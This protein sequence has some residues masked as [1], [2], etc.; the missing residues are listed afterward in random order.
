M[1]FSGCILVPVSFSGRVRWNAGTAGTLKIS[2]HA[3]GR[4]NP[5]RL[6]GVRSQKSKV[7]YNRVSGAVYLLLLGNLQRPTLA[8]GNLAGDIEGVQTF[9]SSRLVVVF[10]GEEFIK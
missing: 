1:I 2:P 7:N 4:E 3:R 6:S 8:V 9:G 5:A 10:F